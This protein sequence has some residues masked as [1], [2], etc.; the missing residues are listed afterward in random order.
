MH[1]RFNHMESIEEHKYKNNFDYENFAGRK[2]IQIGSFIEWIFVSYH[3]T[4][5]CGN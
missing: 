2:I 3:D 1:T 4:H 5:L